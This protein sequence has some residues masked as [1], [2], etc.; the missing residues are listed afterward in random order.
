MSTSGTSTASAGNEPQSTDGQNQQIA[1]NGGQQV[2]GSQQTGFEAITNQEE[3]D[4]RIQARI[5]RE[6]SKFADYDELKDY[7]SKFDEAS[8]KITTLEAT[9]TE[10]QGKLTAVEE[11]EQYAQ[12]VAKVSKD[13]GVPAAA[14]RGSTEEEL[15][16]HAETLKGFVAN[17]LV[18]PGQGNRPNTQ[19]VSQER[20]AVRGL[21]GRKT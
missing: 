15:T 5:A 9:N 7:K 3:F 8:G 1:D 11:K 21:F 10:L 19:T 6:R 14:L 12:L 17:P 16:A 13:S 18:I 20:E 2:A 4:Q